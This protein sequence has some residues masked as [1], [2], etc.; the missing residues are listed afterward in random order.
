MRTTDS[1]GRGPGQGGLG[2]ALAKVSSGE[3]RCNGVRGPRFNPRS[4]HFLNFG[5]LETGIS[6]KPADLKLIGVIE[7]KLS[8]GTSMLNK[9]SLG[10]AK[11]G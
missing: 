8:W 1:T 4:Y 3:M 11:N 7:L 9:Y 10:P 5:F 2:P 6:S